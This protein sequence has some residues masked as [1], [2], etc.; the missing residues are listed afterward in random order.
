[1]ESMVK[2]EVLR[3]ACCIAGSDGEVTSEEQAVLQQLASEVGVGKASLDAMTARA[4]GD[5]E[6]HKE[7]FRVLKANPA[8]TLGVL[9]RVAVA[10]HGLGQ[11]ECQV[12]KRLALQLEVPE[13]QFDTW[14]QQEIDKRRA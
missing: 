3:A 5:P 7:Q 1:M 2:V 12:L 10:D 14:L 6:F 11:R 4:V 8:E 9:L 13:E